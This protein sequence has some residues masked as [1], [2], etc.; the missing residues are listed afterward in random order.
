VNILFLKNDFDFK[1]AGDFEGPFE[2]WIFW[3]VGKL[4]LLN[5]YATRRVAC[6]EEKS[7]EFV[8]NKFL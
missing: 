5:L 3:I 8:Q 6:H 2:C 4:G 7:L 1:P